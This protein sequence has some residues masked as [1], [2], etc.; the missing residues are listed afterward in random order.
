MVRIILSRSP[1]RRVNARLIH[2]RICL[3]RVRQSSNRSK[4]RTRMA[5][6]RLGW[7]AVRIVSMNHWRRHAMPMI[8]IMVWIIMNVSHFVHF[9]VRI[10]VR[11]MVRVM[12]GVYVRGMVVVC[13]MLMVIV[14]LHSTEAAC[15]AADQTADDRDPREPS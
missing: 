14:V 8:L 10:V 3:R 13:L 7:R 1:E 2:M 12:M 15:S 6:R 4:T 11:V 5:M 9:H